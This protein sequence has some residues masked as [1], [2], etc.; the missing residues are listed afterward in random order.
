MT[1][2][3]TPR[4]KVRQIIDDALNSAIPEPWEVANHAADRVLTAL[5]SGSGDHAELE[6][7]AWRV[8]DLILPQQT[9]TTDEAYA[10]HRADYRY[11][12]EVTATVEPLVTAASAEARMREL[13][14]AYC[15]AESEAMTLRKRAAEA[16]RKLAEAVSVLGEIAKGE[17]PPEQHGHYLAHRQAVDAA[18]TFL[19]KD[20]ERG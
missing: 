8:Q 13:R 5:A 16:E 2:P 1:P 20:A 14:S 6:V 11:E 17:A 18:R 19:S 3:M 4:E 9:F 15:A 10:R 7:V 12:G